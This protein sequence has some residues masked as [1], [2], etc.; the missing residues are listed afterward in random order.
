MYNN[1]HVILSQ[2]N[3]YSITAV[4]I[5]LV[6]LLSKFSEEFRKPM[7][8]YLVVAIVVWVILFGYEAKT[9]NN[10]IHVMT[11]KSQSEIEAAKYEEKMIDGRLVRWRKDTGEIVKGK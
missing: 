7:Q 10:L 3:S 6:I 2:I 11:S 9:G 8:G 1:A 5:L 4:L